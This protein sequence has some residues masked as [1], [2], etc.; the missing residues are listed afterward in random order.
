M[1]K[2]RQQ[3]KETRENH[4]MKHTRNQQ[5]NPT[6]DINKNENKKGHDKQVN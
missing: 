3:Y 4:M 5:N 2:I 1:N 6:R